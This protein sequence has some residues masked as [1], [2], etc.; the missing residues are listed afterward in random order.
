MSLLNP[1]KIMRTTETTLRRNRKHFLFQPLWGAGMIMLLLFLADFILSETIIASFGATIFIA[2][3]RPHSR[4]TQPR[5]LI[6]GYSCGIVS[7]LFGFLMCGWLPAVPLAIFAGLAVGL[8]TCLMVGLRFVHPPAG[9][10]AL[11][12]VLS[13]KPFTAALIAFCGII[14]VCVVL[15]FAKPWMQNFG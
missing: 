2:S 6:G 12:L 10:L 1:Q 4:R 15:H 14:T 11:G 3:T 7:G 8:A 9:A 13:Q 5:Y